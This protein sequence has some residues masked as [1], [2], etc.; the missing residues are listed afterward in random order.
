MSDWFIHQKY[1]EL[2]R[3]DVPKL[4]SINERKFN[5]LIDEIIPGKYI[6]C[7]DKEVSGIYLKG[8]IVECPV[9]VIDHPQ[10]TAKCLLVHKQ[11]K[12]NRRNIDLPNRLRQQVMYD[13]G[14]QIARR[15]ER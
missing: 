13:Y 12:I 6:S 4:D 2:L 15:K 1:Y 3:R 11:F 7:G 10:K 9:K 8:K 5:S 14:T